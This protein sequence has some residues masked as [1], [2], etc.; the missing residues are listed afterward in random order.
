MSALACTRQRARIA[1][2][3]RHRSMDGKQDRS[4]DA[5]ISVPI[6]VQTM[7]L[8]ILRRKSQSESN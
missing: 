4:N 8:R 6:R 1:R 3:R 2:L 7:R 5:R